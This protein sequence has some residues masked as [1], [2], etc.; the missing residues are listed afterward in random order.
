MVDS[1]FYTHQGALTLQQIMDLTQASLPEKWS[2]VADLKQEY[3][4]VSMLEEAGEQDVV[5]YDDG[6]YKEKFVG[7]KAGI[8]FIKQEHIDDVPAGVVPL[9]TQFPKR[10]YAQTA[11][12]FYP[13]PD[14]EFCAF[15]DRIHPTA[16]IGKGTIIEPGVVIGENAEIGEG[17][18]I[19]ANAVIGRGVKIGNHC[20]IHMSATVTNSIIG[21]HVSIF[22]GARVGQ[23]GFG[24]VMDEMGC[25]TVP[26]LG[27]VI[28]EDHVE[29]GANTTVDRGALG[30]T[31]IG[32][33]SRT[34]NLVQIGHNVKIG[35]G[36]IIVSQVGISGSTRIGDYVIIAGQAGLTGHL[37]IGDGVKVAAQSGVMRDIPAGE[38]VGGS[39]AVPIK[40]YH[41]QGVMLKRL[42]SGKM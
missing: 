5:F 20:R 29:I 14:H 33:Y 27:R 41:R 11:F 39:P 40:Q 6:R 30:D 18:R 37:T 8:C 31:H 10:A 24:F 38:A 19:G 4:S 32:Q 26:Q 35:K 2:G 23:S 34:D 1:R 21:N 13:E 25:V 15:E 7:T 16:Q 12:A 9:V 3:Q 22:P 42:V 28:L 36:C 17:C